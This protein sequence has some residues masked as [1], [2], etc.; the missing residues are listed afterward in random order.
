MEFDKKAYQHFSIPCIYKLMN[1]L[2]SDH[3][4]KMALLNDSFM[5]IYDILVRNNILPT[6]ISNMTC[7]I[8]SSTHI[9]YQLTEKNYTFLINIHLHT[10]RKEKPHLKFVIKN[11]KSK[12]E[13]NEK[14]LV[15]KFDNELS[16]KFMMYFRNAFFSYYLCG[17]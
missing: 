10:T 2:Q 6:V 12:L 14:F 5:R 16:T 15:D 3:E 8:I 9:F 7:K 11:I 4:K 1:G 17:V 13:I